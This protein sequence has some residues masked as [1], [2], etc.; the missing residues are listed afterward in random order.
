MEPKSVYSMLTEAWD[1]IYRW[2]STDTPPILLM[3]E[4]IKKSQRRDTSKN[5]MLKELLQ[6]FHTTKSEKVKMLEAN[7]GL[8]RRIT[9]H[10]GL[11]RMPAP[12]PK[13]HDAKKAGPV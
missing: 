6:I 13:L 12:C 10:R 1:L 11:E 2:D 7:P 3:M 4:G 9:I 5:F 8:E